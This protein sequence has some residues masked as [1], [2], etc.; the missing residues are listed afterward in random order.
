MDGRRSTSTLPHR[1]PA[2]AAEA[3]QIVQPV[4]GV[5]TEQ[6]EQAVSALASPAGEP[7][8]ESPAMRQTIVARKQD[9]DRCR[10]EPMA[11]IV[12]C[13]PPRRKSGRFGAPAPGRCPG[14]GGSGNVPGPA[15]HN[16][17]PGRVAR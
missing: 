9:R 2:K 5:P 10:M 3:P 7:A 14:T 15:W 13:G 8:H 17:R 12:G 1:R 16:V 4:P 6:H 11:F